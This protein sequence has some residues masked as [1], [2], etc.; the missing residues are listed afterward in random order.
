MSKLLLHVFSNDYCYLASIFLC[1]YNNLCQ[2]LP[3]MVKSYCL[4]SEICQASKEHFGLRM[5]L[6]GAFRAKKVLVYAVNTTRPCDYF[7]QLHLYC[8]YN[9]FFVSRL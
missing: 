3:H 1:I 9:N 2:T 8:I 6:L 5:D 4:N 7:T